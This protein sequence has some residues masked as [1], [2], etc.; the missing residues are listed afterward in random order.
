MGSAF[1][2][3]YLQES[4]MKDGHNVLGLLEGDHSEQSAFERQHNA[5]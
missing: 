4:P 2:I 5:S 3:D 1:D